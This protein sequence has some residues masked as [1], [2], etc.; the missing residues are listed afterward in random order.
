MSPAPVLLMKAPVTHRLQLDTPEVTQG[1]NIWQ[2]SCPQFYST[3]VPQ[4]EFRPVALLY[5]PLVQREQPVAPVE[6]GM[7]LQLN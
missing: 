1:L 5:D 3:S 2:K 7:S 4:L 6:A